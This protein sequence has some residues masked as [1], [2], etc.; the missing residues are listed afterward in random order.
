M[1][2]LGPYSRSATLAK[3]DGR[4]KESRLTKSLRAELIAHCGGNPSTT[5]RI[6]IDQAVQPRLRIAMMDRE[7]IDTGMSERRQ[8]EYLA[9]TGALTR[10]MRNLG[11]KSSTAQPRWQPPAP[12]QP[13]ASPEALTAARA[14]RM[15]QRAALLEKNREIPS[16]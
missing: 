2:K 16:A 7:C 12:A 10:L 9:W 11:L 6:L 8:V 13:G 4:T 1:P 3:L 5:E 14:Q 15:A